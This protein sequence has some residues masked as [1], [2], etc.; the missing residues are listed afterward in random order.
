MTD[1]NDEQLHKEE[2]ETTEKAE[3]TVDDTAK[4][5]EE[6]QAEIE[7]LRKH[8]ETILGEKKAQ[9]EAARKAAQEAAEKSGD[10]E[11]L[12]ASYEQKFGETKAEYED[13]IAGLTGTL[14]K[15]T[16]TRTATELAAELALPGS[17]K[18][19]LPHI[20]ARLKMTMDANGVPEVTVI[21]TDGKPSALSIADLRKEIESDAAFAP[22][23]AG[24]KASGGGAAGGKSGGASGGAKTAK[25]M[26]PAEKSAFISENG[27]DAWQKLV[28]A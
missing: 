7:R 8:N 15:M 6:M 19:L 13:R 12:K 3:A 18:A 22:L 4:K 26:T 9:Q 1:Q 17:A 28:G 11:A 23:L 5:L 10:V 25:D 20:Q 27:L 24:T 16:V 21:D 14:E 2:A